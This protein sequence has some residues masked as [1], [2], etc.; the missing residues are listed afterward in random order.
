MK[1]VEQFKKNTLKK[2]KTICEKSSPDEDCPQNC[3]LKSVCD[4]GIIQGVP[5][6]WEFE[7]KEEN[8][9]QILLDE[10]KKL[11]LVILTNEM[12]RKNITPTTVQYIKN[13]TLLTQTILALQVELSEF[14]NETK[15]FKYWSVKGLQQANM[16]KVKEEFIDTMHF[17]LSL[18]NQLDFSADDL[19]E[20]YQR[21][22]K[23]NY[24][25]Q[26]NNY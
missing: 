19:I 21:K 1:I 24:E 10:Q 8:A 7:E 26:N 9:L 20:E 13:E 11:D 15:C 12:E 3:E 4:L 6:E 25:R 5:A 17:F 22:N 16:D 18:A 2:M 23:I 14:A